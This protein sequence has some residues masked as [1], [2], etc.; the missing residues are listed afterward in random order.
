MIQSVLSPVVIGREEQLGA[1][2]D[3]LLAANGGDGRLIALSGEAGMGKTRLVTELTR[4]ADK[5]GNEVLWGSCADTE[6]SLPY[7]PF[8]EAMGNYLARSDV[9]RIAGLLG[10]AR[11]ELAQLFPQLGDA[12]MSQEGSDAS[13]AKARLFEAVATL[14]A[15]P[16]RERGLLL[17][18]DDVHWADASTR[19]LLDHLTRRLPTMR[20]L[21][22]VTYRSDEI[23]R[24]HPLLPMLQSWRRSRSVETVKLEALPRPEVGQMIGAIFDERD[25]SGELV[26]LMFERSEGNPFVLEEMLKEAIDHGDIY[27]GESG[28]DRKPIDSFQIPDSVRDTVLL[29]LARL[30]P[31]IV[32]VLECASVL[33]RTF[34]VATLCSVT[35]ASDS[36]VHDA[37]NAAVGRQLIEEDPHS[38]GRFRWRHALTQ[39]AIYGDILVSRRE[40]WH[41]R[42]ADVL[43][44]TARAVERAHHLLDAGRFD[45]AVPECL[46]AAEEA[47]A[48]IAWA[49]AITLY[50]RALPHIK[51]TRVRGETLCRLGI[52]Y[53]WS[54]RI[55]AAVKALSDGV[56]ALD[57]VGDELRAAHYRLWLGRMH[58]QDLH[59]D[60]ADEQFARARD[61]LEREGPSA[62]LA[63][64]HLRLAQL[65]L[66]EL[67]DQACLEG[68]ERA[69]HIAEQ[70]GADYERIYSL[71]FMSNA[72]Y[73]LG[74]VDEG[75][76]RASQAY[77]EAMANGFGFVAQN[78]E[79]NRAWLHV[80]MMIPG[81]DEC[82]E[83]L[84]AVA[85][86]PGGQGWPLI[87]RSYVRLV[88]G[89]LEGALADARQSYAL[90]R[91]NPKVWREALQESEVLLEMG[92]ID[93]ALKKLPDLGNAAADAQDLIYQAQVQVRARLATGKVEEAVAIARE[94][95]EQR[96][97][98]ARETLSVGAEAFFAAGMIDEVR[99]L[100]AAGHSH[101][102][103]AG[104]AYLDL[105]DGRL[106]LE[107]GDAAGA[108]PLLRAATD[109]AER[110]GFTL[111][112]ARM[113]VVLGRAAVR[114]GDA[115]LA[116]A[117]FR[118]VAADADRMGAQ[119]IG[120]EARAEA[121]AIGLDLPA[122]VVEP[123]EA[124]LPVGERVITSLFADVR[125]F[126]PMVVGT[127]PEVMV[128]RMT[129]LYR[130]GKSEVERN[131][132]LIDKFAGDAVMA[133]FNAGGTSMDHP[134]QAMKAAFGLRDKAALM[135]LPIGIGLAVGPA[136]VGTAV[137]GGQAMT[138]GPSVNLAA[139]LQSAASAGEIVVSE[140]V[141]RRT[142][143]WLAERGIEPERVE[144]ELKGFDG[145]QVAYRIQA[146]GD[147]AS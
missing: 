28:W 71:G 122:A 41:G 21:L 96:M 123:G 146:G 31:S 79:W 27:R 70:A 54:E 97:V 114:A 118:R 117:V 78:L 49:D 7:L 112:A 138:L 46:K 61:V 140:E 68:S 25:V 137:R 115:A 113:R 9:G 26:D 141:H 128:E 90:M 57:Q 132:G 37:L 8:I 116:E 19:E 73:G 126:T 129:T 39:E 135:D 52:A 38:P 136:M 92:R 105:I 44:G 133:T 88:K 18:V 98:V 87:A 131:R 23:D 147:A 85:V 124:P 100:S 120:N 104:T 12:A 58:W 74:R 33:G 22:V 77:T 11:G 102:T 59:P 142:A 66:F 55:G 111:A 36:S 81:L 107:A 35:A 42:A 53:G 110:C 82:I 103:P 16:A 10:P 125:E 30:D 14:L 89:E 94:I 5:L 130:W 99:D 50:E 139:R 121:A 62:D 34:D 51:E 134:L 24:R 143:D 47:E 64:A 32:E 109:E 119:L 45:E 3:A 83:R 60:L 72:L 15:V 17:V 4:R 80:H 67:D 2:E 75:Y 63:M 65:A 29:R 91:E 108:L 13:L 69:Y 144:L 127:T 86:A 76:E 145:K 1:L 43:A 101:P 106:L 56:A 20:A 48:A 93:E 40:R 6:L 84:F 95:H